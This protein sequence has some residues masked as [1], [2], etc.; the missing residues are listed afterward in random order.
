MRKLIANWLFLNTG[1]YV[2]L[3]FVLTACVPLSDRASVHITLLHLNDVYEITPVNNGTQGGLARVATIRK[4]LANQNPH[5]FMVLAGD[6]FSPSAL[7]TARV[8]GE[9][10]AGRHIVDVMNATG[11]DYATFGNHEFDLNAEQF[12]QRLSESQAIWFSSN[13]MD[14]Q[15]QP[16]PNVE[17]HVIF[18]ATN[19]MNQPVRVGMFGLTVASNPRDYVSYLDP[20]DVAQQ[21]VDA[22]RGQV[23]IL[24]AVTHLSLQEDT[25]LVQTFPEIDLVLGG[26]EHENWQI[27]R[28]P[29]MTPIFKADANARSVYIHD[30]YY[31]T[32]TGQLEIDSQ[33]RLVTADIPDDPEVAQVVQNWVDVAYAGF[34]SQGFEPDRAVTTLTEPLDGTESSVRNQPTR[35]TELIAHGMLHAVPDAELSIFNSGSIR[36]DDVLLPGVIT[37]YDIIRTLP[38]G[39]IVLA[40][41]MQG[42]LLQDVLDQGAA[43]QGRGGYLQTANVEWD[44]AASNWQINGA[45]LDA[46][47]SYLVAIN[48]FLLTGLEA[49]LDFLNR[50]NPDLKVN[51]T[52]IAPDIRNTLIDELQS[53]YGAANQ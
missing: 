49:G 5:T 22:L 35:L 27:W 8:N 20:M 1:L 14:V 47:K 23:E 46:D 18:T 29:G 6:L 25:Q 17:G 52:E 43:N 12:G 37:E 38:F 32:T 28:G 4:Q 42:S 16:L 11:L 7:G 39:G 15:G 34:R 44:P 45:I 48:D 36:L 51:E 9:R 13:V 21:E 40:V 3:L 26:H 50:D 41:E 2:V 31:N 19:T 24:I 53:V 30:L 33:L 10:L